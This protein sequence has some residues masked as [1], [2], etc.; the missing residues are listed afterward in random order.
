MVIAAM[1]GRVGMVGV[2][3]GDRVA[4]GDTIAVTEAMKMEFTLRAPRAG[5]VGIV[6][7]AAGDQIEEGTVIATIEDDDA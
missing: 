3:A 5:R 7:V 2:K 1:P 4:K 6:H